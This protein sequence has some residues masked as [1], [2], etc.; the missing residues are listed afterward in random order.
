VG[1]GHLAAAG[2]AEVAVDDDAVVDE[3][4][5]GDREVSMLLAVRWEAP[6]SLTTWSS[7]PSGLYRAIGVVLSR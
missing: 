6:R 7:A 2:P 3:D 5:R 4:L 1:E